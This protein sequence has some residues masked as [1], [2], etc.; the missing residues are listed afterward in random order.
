MSGRFA[1]QLKRRM[2]EKEQGKSTRDQLADKFNKTATLLIDEF[3]NE[4]ASGN[5]R[6]DDTADMMRLFQIYFEVNELKNAA[7]EGAGTLPQLSQRQSNHIRKYIE[8]EEV[9]TPD[10]GYED[11]IDPESLMKLDEEDISKMIKEREIEI[12]ADN[13]QEWEDGVVG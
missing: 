5:I 9:D 8:T 1:D 2:D 12:N 13:A 10:G 3:M 11:V 4:V 7:G 6:I